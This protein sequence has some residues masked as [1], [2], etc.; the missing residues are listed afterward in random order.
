M[1][2]V[3]CT[4]LTPE[5]VFKTSGHVHKFSDWMCKDTKKGDY[6]RADYLIESV[7]ESRLAGDK[8]ARGIAVSDEKDEVDSKK[9]KR[10]VEDIKAI[11][12]DDATVKEC[13]EI[14]AR[15][16]ILKSNCNK[17]WELIWQY[18]D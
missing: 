12:L 4:V 16:M 10:I 18:P 15:V 9:Q 3:D 14:L 11:K 6:L 7:L 13:Q 8:S 2:E 5:D 17:S 1:L